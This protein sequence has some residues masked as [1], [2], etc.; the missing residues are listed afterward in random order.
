MKDLIKLRSLLSLSFLLFLLPFLRTCSDQ[1]LD[2]LIPVPTEIV[3]QGNET[4]EIAIKDTIKI[5]A[6]SKKESDK[7]LKDALEERKVNIQKAKEEYTYNFYNL[8]I[9]AFKSN[10]KSLDASL[11]SDLSFYP[12]LALILFFISTISM[13][14]LSFFEKTTSITILGILNLL[15]LVTSIILYYASEIIVDL[16][17][18][19]IGFYLTF[20]NTFLIILLARKIKRKEL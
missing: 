15:L 14:I 17:Q 18:I 9:K 6:L 2:K 12:Y 5:E 10:N 4:S 1:S 16:N 13:L 7:Y 20:V 8:L 3:A 11:F 19:K